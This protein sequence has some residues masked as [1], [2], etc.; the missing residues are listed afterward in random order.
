MSNISDTVH[1]MK[2]NYVKLSDE[3][4]LSLKV[5]LTLIHVLG[6]SAWLPFVIDAELH[7]RYVLQPQAMKTRSCLYSCCRWQYTR[8][9]LRK[10]LN[11]D[12]HMC[13][14]MKQDNGRTSWAVSRRLMLRI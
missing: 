14:P 1:G 10:D 12:M 11:P 8:G 3:V 5:Q 4:H 7:P 6:V 13:T 9:N 2:G